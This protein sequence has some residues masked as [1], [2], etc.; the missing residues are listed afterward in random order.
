MP[1]S[2][3]KKEAQRILRGLEA[4]TFSLL[5]EARRLGCYHATI[6]KAIRTHIGSDEF[7]RVMRIAKARRKT[8]RRPRGTSR[9]VRRQLHTPMRSV[10]LDPGTAP[11]DCGCR[12]KLVAETDGTGHALIRCPGCGHT[13][14]VV[15]R[16]AA[17]HASHAVSTTS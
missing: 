9:P 17:G 5:G 4:G 10:P 14:P 2:I 12:E 6:R 16:R 1:S 13:E 15:T 8:G 3:T 7:D 11:H